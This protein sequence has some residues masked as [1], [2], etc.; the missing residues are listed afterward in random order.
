MFGEGVRLKLLLRYRRP[1]I[2]LRDGVRSREEERVR[3]LE[4][5]RP[6]TGLRVTLLL[7]SS[8]GEME[9]RTERDERARPGEGIGE[10]RD[11]VDM[12]RVGFRKREKKER[13]RENHESSSYYVLQSRNAGA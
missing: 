4:R 13:E 8:R 12:M 7:G 1:P 2:R 3:L 9:R 11:C 5:S 10:G 6:R